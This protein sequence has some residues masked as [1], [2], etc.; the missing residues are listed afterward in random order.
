[1]IYLSLKAARKNKILMNY[2][3][4]SLRKFL[5]QKKIQKNLRA[6]GVKINF[7]ISDLDVKHTEAALRTLAEFHAIGI[8]LKDTQPDTTENHEK[9]FKKFYGG[10][11]SYEK[12]ENIPGSQNLQ[13]TLHSYIDDLYEEYRA[14]EGNKLI[15]F[16]ETANFDKVL[17]AEKI[18]RP[19]V[20]TVH[21]NLDISNVMF[22]TGTDYKIKIH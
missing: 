12:A 14:V 22:R 2:Y 10:G 6:S 15:D 21:G 19:W 3:N 18:G 13:C 1:M 9:F 4:Y 7:Q 17:K 11:D 5:K 20:T 8:V 16:V